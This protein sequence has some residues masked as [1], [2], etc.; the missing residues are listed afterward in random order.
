MSASPD[1]PDARN[2]R[3]GGAIALV[4][5][6]TSVAMLALSF[7]AVPLYRLF[8]ASTGYGGTTQVAEAAPGASGPARSHRALRRQCRARARLELRAGDAADQAA[9][10]QDR[11][12]FLQGR[13]SLRP[14]HSRRRRSIMS[15]RTAPAPISTR[16]PASASASRSSTPHETAELPVVFFLDPALEQDETMSGRRHGHAVL[17]VLRREAGRTGGG[18]RRQ[19]GGG[20]AALRRIGRDSAGRIMGRGPRRQGREASWEECCGRL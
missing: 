17:H 16:S 5:A 2:A 10:R 19:A 18:R 15:A 12:G 9:H 8:C 14:R 20:K 7:A 4:A 1:Q 6:G 3:R 11:H 13:Q